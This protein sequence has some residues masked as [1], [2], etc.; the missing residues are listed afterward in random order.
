[1]V[2]SDQK[3]KEIGKTNHENHHKLELRGVNYMVNK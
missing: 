3:E 1:M 2:H